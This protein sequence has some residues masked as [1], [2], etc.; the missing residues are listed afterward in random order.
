LKDLRV[1]PGVI[2]NA[3][4]NKRLWEMFE[5]EEVGKTV[6]RA[7]AAKVR[8]AVAAEDLPGKLRDFVEE[9]SGNSDK[10]GL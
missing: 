8:G 4:R 2:F 7:I 1:L 10:E 3:R 5:Q 6:L 9:L